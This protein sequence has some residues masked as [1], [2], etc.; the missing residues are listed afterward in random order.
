MSNLKIITDSN[1]GITQAEA[2]QLGISVIAM[3]FTINDKEYLED[4]SI[5]HQQFFNFLE[6]NADVK[7]SQPSQYHTIKLWDRLLTVYD[8]LLYIPMTSGLSG[9]YDTAKALS[10]TYNNKVQVV[11]N[12]RISVP[13]KQS[14]LEAVE[15]AK[16]GKKATEIKDYLES[17]ATLSSIYIVPATLKYLKKGGRVS[18]TAA[19]LGDMLKVKPILGSRGGSFDKL[20]MVL[21][22]AQAKRRIIQQL[23]QELETEFKDDYESGNMRIAI[24]HTQNEAEALKFKEEILKELPN[25]QFGEIAPLSLSISCHIGPGA[26]AAGVYVNRYCK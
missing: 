17:T 6:E 10:N 9:T 1:S 21:S 24:A 7:T 8:E 14:V 12:L 4:V 3:P 20:A 25:V 15:L 13:L 16:Q 22:M 19:A 26:L 23:K 5:T 2:E 11:N 18:P